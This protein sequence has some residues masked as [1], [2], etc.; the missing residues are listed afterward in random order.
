ML[1]PAKSTLVYSLTHFKLITKIR[2]L[3]IKTSEEI[4]NEA[5]SG[6]R[7]KVTS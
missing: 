6:D 4:G 1:R 2:V 3:V 7:N 5:K